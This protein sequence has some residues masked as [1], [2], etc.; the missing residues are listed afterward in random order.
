MTLADIDMEVAAAS[1]SPTPEWKDELREK[2]EQNRMT[3]NHYFAT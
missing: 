3:T 1:V 2:W